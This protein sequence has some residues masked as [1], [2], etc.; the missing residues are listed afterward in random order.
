M[1]ADNKVGVGKNCSK[2]KVIDVC[3]K[4]LT[5]TVTQLGGNG[6]ER[7]SAAAAMRQQP[8]MA[9]EPST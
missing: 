1:Q 7:A 2:E 6:T 3:L 4:A 8:V 9:G 5:D